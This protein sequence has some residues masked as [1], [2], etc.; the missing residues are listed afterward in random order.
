MKNV[1]RIGVSAGL[2]LTAALGLQAAKADEALA[3]KRGCTACHAVDNKLVGPGLKEVAA[4]YKD[5][6]AALDMLVA[7]V[8][9]GGS[10]VWG[11]VPMPANSPRVSDEDIKTLVQWILSL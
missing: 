1:I 10:G 5:N 3:Q 9:G 4:K 11:Q 7:K 2:A 6:P 8:K